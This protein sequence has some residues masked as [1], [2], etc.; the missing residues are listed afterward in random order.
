VPLVRALVTLSILAAVLPSTAAAATPLTVVATGVALHHGRAIIWVS[1][2]NETQGA[3]RPLEIVVRSRGTPDRTERVAILRPLQT[4]T[5]S[6]ELQAGNEGAAVVA[7]FRLGNRAE[8]VAKLVQLSPETATSGSRF[9]D[10]LP[11]VSALGGVALG[12]WLNH[13]WSR[14]R[15]RERR[16][17]EW[18][19]MVFEK[20]EGAFR[21][22]LS[23]WIGSTDGAALKNHF[24]RL[25]REML[26]PAHLEEEFRATLEIL[27]SLVSDE[28]K[29]NA[30]AK[31]WRQVYRYAH[32]PAAGLDEE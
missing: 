26:M 5:R 3:L 23:K 25:R 4:I 15:D 29:S 14:Q 31:F 7:R 6:Y 32:H 9:H 8:S 16:E 12:A 18:S 10:V 19:Q 22:F 27:E 17:S 1:V 28:K 2:R 21:E 30:A 24:T 20:Y 13:R 11:V